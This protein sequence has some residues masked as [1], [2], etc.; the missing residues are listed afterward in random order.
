M[1]RHDLI[2]HAAMIISNAPEPEECRKVL[3]WYYEK[4]LRPSNRLL[5]ECL[6]RYYTYIDIRVTLDDIEFHLQGEDKL[7]ILN[8][9]LFESYTRSNQ[10]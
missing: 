9:M 2:E 3:Y 4:Q 5:V 6:Q 7:S 8:D 10:D 1:A